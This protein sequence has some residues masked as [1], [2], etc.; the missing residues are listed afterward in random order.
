MYRHLII[1]SLLDIWFFSQGGFLKDNKYYDLTSENKTSYVT[2]WRFDLFLNSGF[3]NTELGSNDRPLNVYLFRS[4]T[5]G[6]NPACFVKKIRSSNEQLF[7]LHE[8][9]EK[10]W[11]L[12]VYYVKTEGKV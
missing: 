12:N 5:I 10:S 8:P 3:R 11:G 6:M 1:L 4:F 7:N 2:G 9:K